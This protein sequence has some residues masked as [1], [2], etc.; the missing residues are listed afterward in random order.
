[1]PPRRAKPM[2]TA[3]WISTCASSASVSI[4][5]PLLLRAVS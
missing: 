1:M 5:S 4:D 3:S 2:I